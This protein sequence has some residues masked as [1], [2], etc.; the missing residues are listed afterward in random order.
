MKQ[1]DTDVNEFEEENIDEEAYNEILV[2]LTPEEIE[3]V[4]RESIKCYY[5]WGNGDFPSEEPLEHIV[6]RY[7]VKLRKNP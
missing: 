6:R 2:T 7:V 3:Q 5:S 1:E 4:C